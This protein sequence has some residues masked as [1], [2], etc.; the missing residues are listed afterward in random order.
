MGAS[1]WI[2]CPLIEEH[3][4]TVLHYLD[5]RIIIH[6]IITVRLNADGLPPVTMRAAS[7]SLYGCK[8]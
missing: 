4:Y 1:E 3:H 2:K 5:K 6:A 7:V 8:K